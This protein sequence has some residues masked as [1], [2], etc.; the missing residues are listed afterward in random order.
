[1]SLSAF[2]EVYV[3]ESVDPMPN[4]GDVEYFTSVS[5]A[6]RGVVITQ[7]YSRDEAETDVVMVT[8]DEFRDIVQRVLEE[9]GE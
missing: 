2:R 7:G 4:G 6:D 5:L 8:F 3:S 9:L 1:M